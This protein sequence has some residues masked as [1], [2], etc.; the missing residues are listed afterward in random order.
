MSN[1]KDLGEGGSTLRQ[2]LEQIRDISEYSKL[3]KLM[4]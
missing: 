2:Q 1:D 4:K 3:Q